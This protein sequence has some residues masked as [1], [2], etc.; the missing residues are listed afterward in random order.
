MISARC[1]DVETESCLASS[2]AWSLSSFERYTT[3]RS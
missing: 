2:M 1:F 3:R